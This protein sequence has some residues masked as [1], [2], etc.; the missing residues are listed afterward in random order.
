MLLLDNTHKILSPWQGPFQVTKSPGPVN[1]EVLQMTP[2][3]R[4]QIYH[5]NLLRRWRQGDRWL[6]KPVGEIKED[7]GMIIQDLMGTWGG[8]EIDDQL[9]VN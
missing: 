6:M 3:R 5:I 1:Y 2:T 8:P 4:K 9:D 7:D